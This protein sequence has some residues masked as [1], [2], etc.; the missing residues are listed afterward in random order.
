MTPKTRYATTADGVRVAY[1][2]F[3]EGA[4]D[5][6]LCFG[7][8]S[9]VDYQW[10]LPELRD[11]LDRLARFS[12]VIVFDRRGAGSSDR[13]SGG[14]VAPLEVGVEDVV[15]VL[16]AVGSE[17]TCVWGHDD[18]ALVAA[19]FA[20][21]HPDRTDALV[22][23]CPEPSGLRSPDWPWAPDDEQ[24][25]Q[26]VEAISAVW[27]TAEHTRQTL[28]LVA[29]SLPLTSERI[30]RFARYFRLAGSPATVV[31]LQAILRDSDI[32]DVLSAIRVPTLVTYRGTDDVHM[33]EAARY[34]AAQIKGARFAP[35]DGE[36]FALWADSAAIC[37]KV[38]EFL[39]GSRTPPSTNHALSTLL[40]A[41]VVSTAAEVPGHDEPARATMPDEFYQH[42]RHLVSTHRG[43]CVEQSGNQLLARFDGPARAVGCG[44]ALGNDARLRGLELRTGCHTGEVELVRD[45]VRGGAVEAAAGIS[46]LAPA[47]QIWTSA[48]VRAL[49]AGS[50][51]SFDDRGTHRLDRTPGEWQLYSA[52]G[53]GLG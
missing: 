34:V 39:L 6:V 26:N 38:E 23:H 32:R 35:M 1:Q 19:L 44:L 29:P 28:A 53:D 13:F 40:F 10:E 12:R 27:G 36:D 16:D 42:A 5:L 9:C 48:T 30:D 22:L 4:H 33:P 50:G 14:D 20:A 21:I 37:A 2:V 46:A 43:V 51:L 45:Q 25:A 15:A 24:W 49:T 52:S 47:G 31:A 7:M 41:D 17:R 11:A 3:G 18:G 8:I